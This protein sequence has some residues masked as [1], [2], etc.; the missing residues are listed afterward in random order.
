[1]TDRRPVRQKNDVLFAPHPSKSKLY[2]NPPIYILIV[3]ILA[4]VSHNR[5]VNLISFPAI[6]Y[7]NFELMEVK[8]INWFC[9][10]RF[11]S[12]LPCLMFWGWVTIHGKVMLLKDDYYSIIYLVFR[13]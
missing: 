6:F 8:W 7:H 11:H 5:K 1:M 9:L 2:P 12:T 3:G 13:C 10:V 4:S